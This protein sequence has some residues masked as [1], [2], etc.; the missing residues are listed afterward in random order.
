MS[1]CLIFQRPLICSTT[2]LESMR[3]WISSSDG[4]A[5]RIFATSMASSRALM[6]PWYSATLLVAL[7]MNSQRAATSWSPSRTELPQ[8]AMPGLPRDPPSHSTSK[9]II[10]HPRLPKTL[11]YCFAQPRAAVRD[12]HA[13]LSQQQDITLRAPRHFPTT[14]V[15][16]R[17]ELLHRQRV[18]LHEA[19]LARPPLQL[20]GPHAMLG[21]LLVVGL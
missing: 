17:V 1:G 2:S 9:R 8:P 4:A 3:T 6:S 21:H 20:C 12:L 15:G 14:T 10:H 19:R 16:Q 7:A 5:P 18:E 11:V 13:T